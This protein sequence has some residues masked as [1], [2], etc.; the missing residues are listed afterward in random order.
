MKDL[1]K[2]KYL[3]W[4]CIF[5]LRLQ[6]KDYDEKKNWVSNFRIALLPWGEKD[7]IARQR[8][9]IGKFDPQIFFLP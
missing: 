2:C 8:R 7:A 5:D 4:Y 6:A 9:G 3:K 1:L